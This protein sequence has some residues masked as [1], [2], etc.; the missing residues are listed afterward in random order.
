MI[1]NGKYISGGMAG[2]SVILKVAGWCRVFHH[3]TEYLMIGR[4]TRPTKASMA[5]ALPA[6][7]GL[8]MEACRAITPKYRNN[9][10]SMEVSRASQ[11]Q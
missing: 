5:E 10:T 3:S 9:N 1:N 11:T 8:A 7:V 2:C 4:F 6:A